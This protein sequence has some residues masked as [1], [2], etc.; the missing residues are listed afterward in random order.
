[1]E[2]SGI[3]MRGTTASKAKWQLRAYGHDLGSIVDKGE[4]VL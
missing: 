4:L 2:H 3:R 1:M